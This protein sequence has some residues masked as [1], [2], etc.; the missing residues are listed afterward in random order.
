MS[1]FNLNLDP[2]LDPYVKTGDV[3]EERQIIGRS[4][5]RAVE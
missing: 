5:M 1:Y 4:H 3:R 2:N